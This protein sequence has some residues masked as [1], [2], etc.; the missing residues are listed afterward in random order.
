MSFLTHKNHFFMEIISSAS[1]YFDGLLFS[2]F[3]TL[4]KAENAPCGGRWMKSL[5]IMLSIITILLGAIIMVG[6]MGAINLP[7]ATRVM[8]GGGISLTAMFIALIVLISR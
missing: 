6:G 7:G 2:F 4:I 1:R 3:V 5:I 8:L